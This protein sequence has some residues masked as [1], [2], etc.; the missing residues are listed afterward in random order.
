MKLVAGQLKALAAIK[1]LGKHSEG[2]KIVVISGAAGTGKSTLL[3]YLS[4]DLGSDV[5]MLAPTGK[6]ALRLRELGCQARTIHSWMFEPKEDPETGDLRFEVRDY[7]S[8]QLPPCGFVVIDEASMLGFSVF[9]EIFR[10][11]LSL[12]LNLVLIGDG[13]QLPPVDIS[14]QNFSIFNDDFPAY[15]KIELTEIH[16]QALDNPIIRISKEILGA[17]WPADAL[18]ELQAMGYEKGLQEAQELFESGDGVT[19]CHRNAT[20][21]DIN[22]KIRQA[23]G[24][25][26]QS[27]E[28]GEPLLVMANN[29]ELDLYNGEILEFRDTKSV[30]DAPIAVTDRHK[31]SSIFVDFFSCSVPGLTRRAVIADREVLGTLGTV[32]TYFVQKVGEGAVRKRHKGEALSAPSYLHANLGYAL[33]CHKAQGSEWQ[34]GLVVM[35]D[36]V[37]LSTTE[38]RRWVYTA[39]SRFKKDVKLIWMPT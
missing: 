35:E 34:R 29:Y 3:S 8:V 14:G 26:S 9:K 2:G 1:D 11:C 23:L 31:N 12:K 20:R 24:Y 25:G 28:E 10:Y 19:I 6:A 13:N 30:T 32:G 7:A 18:S 15:R 5:V 17:K 36:S 16:R 21:H 37:R 4:E 38:G 39:L 27:P 22:A 33:T